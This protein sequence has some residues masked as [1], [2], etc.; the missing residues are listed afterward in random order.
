[1]VILQDAGSHYGHLRSRTLRGSLAEQLAPVAAR[2]RGSYSVARPVSR[3]TLELRRDHSADVF[4]LA[5]DAVINW[6]KLRARDGSH[7]GV[8]RVKPSSLKVL[9]CSGRQLSVSISLVIGRHASMTAIR[10]PPNEVG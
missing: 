1:M 10:R 2:L 5:R 6:V 3:V 9:A 7:P 4:A 8:E